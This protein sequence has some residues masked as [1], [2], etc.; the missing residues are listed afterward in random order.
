MAPRALWCAASGACRGRA[1]LSMRG[2]L[3]TRGARQKGGKARI[4]EGP[5]RRGHIKRAHL[6]RGGGLVGHH[7]CVR[8]ADFNGIA[9]VLRSIHVEGEERTAEGEHEDEAPDKMPREIAKLLETG[10][11]RF[12]FLARFEFGHAVHL[13]TLR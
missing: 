4:T 9:T 12:L 6:G 5:H 1:L 10:A 13:T 8:A 11:Q 7:T 3:Q 2:R